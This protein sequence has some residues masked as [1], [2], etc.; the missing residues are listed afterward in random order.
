MRS[1]FSPMSTV[2]VFII[3]IL[4]NSVF[5]TS[6]LL[7]FLLYSLSY[8]EFYTGTF[9]LSNLGMFGVDR[10]DAIL[11]PGQVSFNP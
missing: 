3:Q 6:I 7:A 10:F 5:F 2:Q 4:R 11:P 1:N 9:T 8:I